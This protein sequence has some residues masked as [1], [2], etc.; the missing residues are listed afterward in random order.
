MN[1]RPLQWA[2]TNLVSPPSLTNYDK[3]RAEVYA[4]AVARAKQE[5]H[6]MGMLDGVPEDI[7]VIKSLSIFDTEW[8]FAS[9]RSTAIDEGVWEFGRI[10][11]IESMIFD[12]PDPAEIG[13]LFVE[14]CNKALVD[15]CVDEGFYQTETEREFRG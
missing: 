13:R 15:R 10:P 2:N 1:P 5:E 14:A 12:N 8:G 3:R 7:G 6:A 9:T 4:A 11:S